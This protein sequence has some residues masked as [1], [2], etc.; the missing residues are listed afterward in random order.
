MTVKAAPL[1]ISPAAARREEELVTENLPL[2]GYLVSEVLGRVPSHVNRDELTSAGLAAL[3]HAARSY[4]EERGV[5]F[6]RFATTRIRGALI[7]ELRSYD[8]A[9]RSVRARARKRN[10]AE[11]ELTATL[12]R[13]PTPEEVAAFL[14]VA[15]AELDS[16][17]EDVQRAVVLSLHGFADPS[18][19]EEMAVDR[20]FTPDD[21][22]L[23]R[24]RL[25]YLH[26]AVAVLPDRLK[27][28]V[29]RYFFEE[30]PMAEIADE[31]GVSESRVSQMRAE[32][33]AL[34]KD[35]MNAQLDP[36]LV[37]PT[38]RPGGCAARRK[39]A[40]YSAIAARSDYRTRLAMP[41][42]GAA[43][44]TRNVVA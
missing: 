43:A 21:A 31:L 3:A 44:F 27:V 37:T 22:L 32:A 13:T 17:E 16:M 24:E 36:E 1:Q 40:Y 38:E 30:R 7:D 28:V 26:D 34:L 11:E 33:L 41:S 4:Q 39:A 29:E 6:A 25:G 9:S 23:H 8:W 15:V 20:S 10:A 5:P 12:G 35:G 19:V 14:G 18:A 2:V 42:L